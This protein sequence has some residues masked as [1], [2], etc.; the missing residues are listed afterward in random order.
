MADRWETYRQTLPK[1]AGRR[2]SVPAVRLEEILSKAPDDDARDTIRV[3]LVE[4]LIRENIAEAEVEVTKLPTDHPALHHLSYLFA[5][6]Y[7]LRRRLDRAVI[8]YSKVDRTSY[9]YPEATLRLAQIKLAKSPFEARDLLLRLPPDGL[10]SHQKARRLN[11]LGEALLKS[12]QK[13]AATIVLSESWRRYPRTA[14]KNRR[15]FKKVGIPGTFESVWKILRTQRGRKR[16]RTLNKLVRRWKK[17]REK[18]ATIAYAF[19]RIY[20]YS[21]ERDRAIQRFDRTLQLSRDLRL[22]VQA[23]IDA[24]LTAYQLGDNPRIILSVERASKGLRRECSNN[25]PPALLVLDRAV[26]PVYLKALLAVG[27]TQDA[28]DTFTALE[29]WTHGTAVQADML[30]VLAKTAYVDGALDI[31]EE[32][33][34]RLLERYP[35]LHNGTRVPRGIR[36]LRWLSHLAH[37]NQR[38]G[39]EALYRAALKERW[40]LHAGIDPTQIYADEIST[41]WRQISRPEMPDTPWT[42]EAQ[43]LLHA[44]RT[45]LALDAMRIT[46]RRGRADP[47]TVATLVHTALSLGRPGIGKHVLHQYGG[48]LGADGTLPDALLP[49]VF[50]I[51]FLH[52]IRQ[53][54]H[55]VGIPADLLAAIVYHESAFNPK[56]RSAAGAIGLAQVMPNTA[57][58]IAKRHLPE[59]KV[60]RR[61]LRDP[62]TNLVVG[63]Y[64]LADYLKLYDGNEL[65]ALIAYNAGPSRFRKSFKRVKTIPEEVQI[66]ILSLGPSV[67]YARRV[68]AARNIYRLLFGSALTSATDHS[69][70]SL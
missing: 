21:R 48:M 9:R 32:Y 62:K 29:P 70:E 35:D 17:N 26:W 8:W 42:R 45:R 24:A 36:A 69:S 63:A 22:R 51:R 1:L 60:N 49:L 11:L 12:G 46:F 13:K 44:G 6:R 33:F 37:I 16:T 61:I 5:E 31:A 2:S 15:L 23:D 66:D 4:R 65:K 3:W 68:Q 56:A 50:S 53:A 64:V 27:R 38:P 59:L 19:G 43:F 39:E 41:D 54:A 67:A 34:Q 7:R 57:K 47:H 28:L 40:P 55:T 30:E 25:C 58:I 10:T 20:R 18:T 52:E 14:K